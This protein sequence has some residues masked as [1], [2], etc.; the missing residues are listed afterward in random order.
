MDQVYWIRNTECTDIKI[1][2]YVG[3]SQNPKRRLREHL[4]NNSR[5]PKDVWIEIIFE[6]TREDCFLKE[7][8][9]RPVKNVGWNR[10]VG[11]AQGFKKGFVHSEQT[12]EKLKAAWTA[13]RK[14]AASIQKA[15]RNKLLKGQKR[16]KQSTA[17]SGSNNPMFGQ[18]HS[19]E[20]IKKIVDANRG[21]IAYN[22]QDLYCIGCHRR[23]SQHVLLRHQKCWKKY[24]G[25][26]K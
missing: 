9:L 1:H 8:E 26:N 18:T 7:E 2:G 19:A 21:K 12:R 11:G 13:E 6:G 23:A 16:P 14:Q 4:K 24:K 5:I 10:A 22:R 15:E 20:A 17:M 3:V 25:D